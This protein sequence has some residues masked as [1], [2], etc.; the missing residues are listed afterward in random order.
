MSKYTSEREV[1]Q[2]VMY[3]PMVHVLS[4]DEFEKGTLWYIVTL[5]YHGGD[6]GA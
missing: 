2:Q 4:W 3:I 5:R 6:D 1:R